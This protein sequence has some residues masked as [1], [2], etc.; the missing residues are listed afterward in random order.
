MFK[1]AASK[2][3]HNSTLPALG[4][5]RDLRPLQDLITAEKAVLITLQKLSVDITKAADALRV[6]G[7]GEGDDLGDILG[8]STAVLGHFAA[9]LSSYASK[10]HAIRDHLKAI[11][12]R[13]EAL[14]ELKRR[15]KATLARADSA[16]KKLNK[17]GAEH[18]NLAAQTDT[19]A[20]LQAQIRQM[21]GEIMNEEA[22]LG[23]FKRAS[24]R[25]FMG[26]KFG[27]L[28][29]VSE[30]GCI[31]AEMGCA[32]ASEISEDVT[33]PGLARTMYMGHQ[34]TS[35][36]VA[37]AERAVNEITFSGVLQSARTAPPR[38]NTTF[39][40][41]G[42]ISMQNTGVSVFN[43]Q[44]SGNGMDSISMQNT[45]M[46]G[47]PYDAPPPANSGFLP[48]PDAG[49]GFLDGRA[50][51]G[52]SF[53]YQP[54]QSQ[55]PPSPGS[56]APSQPGGYTASTMS[57]AYASP[58]APGGYSTPGGY[59]YASAPGGTDG[60][61]DPPRDDPPAG[62]SST[63]VGH[64]EDGPGGGRFATF[65]VRA[66][67][68]SNAAQSPPNSYSDAPPSLGAMT[69][70]D[71]SGS[72]FMS[73]V[74]DV[75]EFGFLAQYP[76]DSSA[77][78]APKES[79]AAELANIS[80]KHQERQRERQQTMQE[81]D[82]VPEYRDYE[83]E[84]SHAQVYNDYTSGTSFV[85]GPP[86]GAA[87]PAIG[88]SW[89]SSVPPLRP[90]TNLTVEEGGGDRKS[91]VT[92]ESED[93]SL[94]YMNNDDEEPLPGENEHQRQARLSK[95]VRFGGEGIFGE[96]E[97]PPVK[98]KDSSP[99]L[100]KRVPPPAFDSELDERALN[101]AAA[102]EIS[103][104]MD[105][106]NFSPPPPAAQQEETGWEFA[107]TTPVREQPPSPQGDY[108]VSSP[109]R[110]PTSQFGSPPRDHM[111]P[112]YA[113]PDPNRSY[114]ASPPQL[115]YDP[116]STQYIPPSTQYQPSQYS[117][118]YQYQPPQAPALRQPSPRIPSV[119]RTGTIDGP[120]HQGSPSWDSGQGSA[121]GS[122]PFNPGHHTTPSWALSPTSP[123]EGP[124][125]P[126]LEA[127]YRA[128]FASRSTSSLNSQAGQAPSG[129]R[130]IS[131]AAFRRPQKAP[132]SGLGEVAD[133]SPLAPKKRLPA[134][135]YPQ[136]GP[137][138]PQPPAPPADDGFDYIGAYERDSKAFFEEPAGN[139]G[140]PMQAD[141]G[142]LGNVQVVGGP[143]VSPRYGEYER[144]DIR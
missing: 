126:R 78:P 106:L 76:S 142:R 92:N 105:A 38:L 13:E 57:N 114:T 23:D 1:N 19:L 47:V 97:P 137:S 69:R 127:P 90:A 94:A 144:D 44:Y 75:G 20:Q 71:T 131:A 48:P 50:S 130:T 73:S 120:G 102:R 129:V 8:A 32:I 14:D 59:D 55:A 28:L 66:R 80:A 39:V 133:T 12:T 24:A 89:E 143:P 134:S 7:T 29:E 22:A 6:W 117:S 82:P 33:P 40:D 83:P 45:G 37:E 56:F 25:A 3:A 2:L 124:A 128:P 64:G 132:A 27:G 86:P 35:Q 16:E 10:E 42:G 84:P 98:R 88:S 18:K 115:Q 95:H 63:G 60:F 74:L 141:F 21:D 5:N 49:S 125:S 34:Q 43:A 41:D 81:E 111:S 31:V 70:K 135:P 121:G 30:K 67:G 17:M 140:S 61:P 112:Q 118:Q 93:F 110:E 116:P 91:T 136:R 77:P 122:Q 46:S 119:S 51:P 108:V 107:T 68:S 99:A 79:Q 72:D 139:N 52:S 65:P 62:L 9:V 123:S 53:S 138:Q 58:S 85:Q 26:L 103:R 101:A 15:R 100:R 54:P 96:T 11:R 87:A 36:R 113:Q 4:G 109:V 104:E